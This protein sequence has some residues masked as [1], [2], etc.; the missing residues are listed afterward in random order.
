MS[1]LSSIARTAMLRRSLCRNFVDGFL[2]S[3]GC[4]GCWTSDSS[5]IQLQTNQK[6]GGNVL[7]LLWPSHWI[8]TRRS[9]SS[10]PT[11]IPFL[12]EKCLAPSSVGTTRSPTWNFFDAPTCVPLLRSSALTSAVRQ[13]S[14]AKRGDLI[15]YRRRARYWP[16]KC[17]WVYMCSEVRHDKRL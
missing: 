4:L 14:L 10:N 9:C 7:G 1:G 12:Q 8:L 16:R 5:V 6:L 15:K 13:N 2:G 11:T 17:E 3:R